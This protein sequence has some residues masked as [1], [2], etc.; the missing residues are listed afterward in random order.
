M[1]AK[2]FAVIIAPI[3]ETVGI[4][5]LVCGAVFAV[6][7][8][9]GGFH[10]HYPENYERL[11]RDLARSILLGL[12]FMVAADIISTVT[13]RPT[14][15]SVAVLAA[16]VLI[17]TFLSFSLEVEINGRWPWQ[18]QKESS[19]KTEAVSGSLAGISPRTT[20]DF[21]PQPG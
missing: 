19:R 2:T 1:E 15:D 10:S 4:A 18:R 8:F 6:I 17:R 12:E 3:I 9:F 5:T 20:S 7:R 16:I 14:L 11:R 13:I 21:A